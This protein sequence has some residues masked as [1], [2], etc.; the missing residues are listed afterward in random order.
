MLLDILCPKRHN[1]L[2]QALLLLTLLTFVSCRFDQQL[3]SIK[4][5][6]Q[7]ILQTK[8]KNNNEPTVL[9]IGDSIMLQQ[10]NRI[11]NYSEPAYISCWNVDERPFHKVI[12]HPK[13]IARKF[14]ILYM[15]FAG[16]HMLHL[17]KTRSWDISYI[18]QIYHF[19]EMV[20]REVSKFSTIANRV[21]LMTPPSV[22]E[23]RYTDSYKNW[24]KNSE[25]NIQTT[26]KDY[27]LSV[28]VKAMKPPV[29]GRY[30]LS[31][32]DIAIELCRNYT[33]TANG[34]QHLAQDIISAA[35]DIGNVTVFDY[36][37]WTKDLDCSHARDGRHF[38]VYTLE[39][40]QNALLD[41]LGL[42]PATA[43]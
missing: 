12:P 5:G 3:H 35:E 37:N 18:R 41:T 19:P 10:R 23:S 43:V 20:E 32:P 33:M 9:T 36:Y 7:Q 4:L 16:L 2:S 39:L 8:E 26:C 29:E 25:T 28:A 27:V 31:D 6:D 15:N 34:A 17:H 42:R 22:C 30:N 11:R 14:D 24:I 40:I 38:D 1:F 13:N 21:V